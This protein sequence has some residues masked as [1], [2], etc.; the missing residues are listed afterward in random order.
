LRDGLGPGPISENGKAWGPMGND[1]A[2]LVPPLTVAAVF[3]AGVFWVVRREMGGK[4]RREDIQEKR[5]ADQ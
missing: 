4:R 1:L 5:R 3:F 2:A